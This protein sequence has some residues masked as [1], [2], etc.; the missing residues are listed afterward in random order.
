MAVGDGAPSL[1]VIV[2]ATNSPPTL[3]RCLDALRA[4]L[5]PDDE[6]VVVTEPA[7]AGPAAAR[8]AGVERAE[9]DVVAF[10]DAD[11]AVHPDAL[12]R[13]RSAFSTD[14]DLVA[15]FGSY[16]DAPEDQS[17]VSRFRNLLHHH[18]H[19]SNA[20]P[21]DTFWAGL[22]AV[23]RDAFI[24]Q[25]GFDAARYR[26]PSIEDI[27]LGARLHAAGAPIVLD[28]EIRGT[29]LKRWSLGSMVSTDLNQRGIPWV[30]LQ[31]EAGEVSGSLNLSWANRLSALAS[32]AAALAVLRRRPVLA[33]AAIGA[34]V[35]LNA[36]FYALL[37]RVGGA[38]LVLAGIPLH[39]LHHLVSALSVAVGVVEHLSDH[40]A[41]DAPPQPR[42]R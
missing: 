14:P 31:L 33:G 39:V 8:N 30:R 20:G 42:R 15:A 35:A 18:V 4:S 32:V 36:R 21:A 2:P 23:R 12:E 5:G 26:E 24:A 40:G 11:V 37:R 7:G 41:T 29:H 25:G 38:P 13:L 9:S 34:L 19:T 28:P 17:A 3:D 27:E 16:D 1:A 6:L 22:G 10:V